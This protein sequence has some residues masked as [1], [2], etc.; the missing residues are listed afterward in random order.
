MGHGSKSVNQH[1]PPEVVLSDYWE[2]RYAL[3][4]KTVEVVA[5]LLCGRFTVDQ[6]RVHDM[7]HSILMDSL[8]IDSH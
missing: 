7:W 8:E 1:R 4:R 5:A 3:L 2:R 6:I